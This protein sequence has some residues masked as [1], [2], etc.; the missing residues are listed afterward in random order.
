MPY[1]SVRQSGIATSMPTMPKGAASMPRDFSCCVC[2]AWSVA[3]TDIVPSSSASTRASLSCSSR[4]GGAIFAFGPKVS[5]ALSV[6]RRWCGVASPETGIP[7]FLAIRSISTLPLELR[8]CRCTLHPVSAASIMSLAT[9][10]SSAERGCPLYPSLFAQLP[11]CITPTADS[12]LS[13]QW[14]MTGMPRLAAFSIILRI[15]PAC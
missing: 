15:R 13:S 7:V 12:D 4:N 14:S 6:R 3:M 10:S 8:C 11:A 9:M 2:G 5:T 1:S